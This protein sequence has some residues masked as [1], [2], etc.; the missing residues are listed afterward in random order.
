MK[1]ISVGQSC[2]RVEVQGSQG[3]AQFN[4]EW[5]KQFNVGM[6]VVITGF[7][8]SW[9]DGVFFFKANSESTKVFIVPAACRGCLNTCEFFAG[10]GG[11]SHAA[12][13]MGI[14]PVLL[15][16]AEENVA[17]ATAKKLGIPCMSA[18]EYVKMILDGHQVFKCMLHDDVLNPDT[19]VVVGLANIAYL[20]G[21]PP[22]QPW[23]SAGSAQGLKC[24]D[25]R[26]FLNTLKQAA[27]LDIRAAVIENVPGLPKHQDFRELI[28][29]IEAEGLK[30]HVQGTFTCAKI[31]PVQRDR[32]LGTFIHESVEVDPAKRVMANA[33]SFADRAFESVAKCPTIRDADVLHVNMSSAEMKQLFICE[34]LFK[35]LS[36]IEYAPTWLKN[37]L[38][39]IPNPSAEQVLQARVVI[40][41]QQFIGFMAM[42][43]KQHNIPDDLLKAK[44]LQT[45]VVRD[46]NGIRY[47]SPWEMI[48]SMGYASDTILSADIEVSWRMAGNGLS[49]AHAWLQLY[50][51]HVLLGDE[52]PFSPKGTPVQQVAAFQNDAIK[53]SQWESQIAGH[54]WE[55]KPHVEQPPEKKVRT[56]IANTAYDVESI[57]PTIPFTALDPSEGTTCD[58]MT[59]PEFA[60]I[61]DPRGIA[62]VGSV[63]GGGM[64]ALQHA[65]KNW[66]MFV[67]TEPSEVV[68]K[69]VLKAL[70]HAKI[71]HFSEMWIEGRVVSWNQAVKCNPSQRLV[72]CPVFTKISCREESLKVAL[73]LQVDVTWTARTAVAYSAVKLGCN[74]DALVVACNR[75]PL[76]DDDFLLEYETTEFQ[77]KFK[78][79]MPGYISW[80]P[81]ARE[82]CD[83]G[84]APVP[85]TMKR[86][87][88]RHPTKKTVRT[89]CVSHNTSV[90]Q[91]VQGV[92]PDLHATTAW[93]A[94]RDDVEIKG[95][96]KVN[97]IGAIQVQWNGFRPL[98]ATVIST[99]R[100]HGKSADDAALQIQYTCSGVKRHVRSP[101]KVRCDELTLAHDMTIGEIA[102]SFMTVAQLQV[103][104]ICTQGAHVLDPS[105]Y[106]K[107]TSPDEVLSFR[108]CPL[109]GGAKNDARTRIGE[110]LRSKGVPENKLEERLKGLFE[111]VSPDKFKLN[112]NDDAFWTQVKTVAS[113][114][115]YRLITHEELKA[116][117]AA[118]RKGKAKEASSAVK[119]KVEKEAFAVDASRIAIDVSHF[120]ANDD[121]VNLIEATRFGPDQTGLCVV[122][123][124]DVAKWSTAGVKSCDPL[125]LL[126]VGK[127]CH[128]YGDV[129][130]IP[131]HTTGGTPIIV[132]GCI[133][134]YGDVPIEFNLRIPSVVVDQVASTAIEFTIYRSH[135]TCWEDVTVPLHYIGVHIPELRGSNLL[136]TWSIKSWNKQQLSHVSKADHWHGFFRIADNMLCAVL[137]R[138]GGA[139]IFLNPKTP[140]RKHDPRFV[141]ISLPNGKLPDVLAKAEACP[142]AVGVVKKGE[143]YC[144]RCK[145]EDADQMRA[146]L[147]PETAYVETAS[148]SEDET[149]YVLT[150]VPQINRDELTV[151][152]AKASWKANAIKP[153]GMKR[154]LVAAKHEPPT[155]HLG[156]NG[157]IVVVEKAKKSAPAMQPVTMFARE[158]KVDT[159]RDPANN[160]VQVSTTSRI[161]EFK[162][163]MDDQITA[164]VDQRLAEAH[165]KIEELQ[166]ALTDV[167]ETAAKC[168]ANMSCDMS[169]MKQEQTFTR[170]KLLE[171]EASVATSGQAIIQQMQSMFATMQSSLEKTVQ[172][173]M[174]VEAEKRPRLDDSSRN[175]PFSTKAN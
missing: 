66:V 12:S 128:E 157:M 161:A 19:W 111:K 14:E 43:G 113:E 95:S 106:A 139:G 121:S 152:L 172:Q 154:W 168:H 87:F 129:F 119:P 175:D 147:M 51:T 153:Q 50:K 62:V 6:D 144:I 67:N 99:M 16:D 93:T 112:L 103:S 60:Q 74:P 110:M 71:E 68:S 123:A 9:R 102:A 13:K 76:K 4:E 63:Y 124:C 41:C 162:A 64:I 169:Q 75:I 133:I 52:S 39:G 105:V 167:K 59:M 23:S 145:R 69:I 46:A 57:P 10:L 108:I 98:R 142:K 164:A 81:C 86:W 136:A 34:E 3:M 127:G 174:S 120:S 138:S 107:D 32:W 109:I 8:L 141:A 70:P 132:Q 92:F 73:N 88:A 31:L 48:A 27:M 1:I 33:I 170:Q 85:C 42:Y 114:N 160:V 143:A 84:M 171:V 125:A 122:N 173:S 61:H 96:D 79:C 25:G 91:L 165:A 49:V 140:D 116:F 18:S 104:M 11:W 17:R 36:M 24:H 37:R 38:K 44:G 28:S 163:Q 118:G 166:T 94:F 55:L 159:I 58:L 126:V 53:L 97:D 148:F 5:C 77:L 26:V 54:F 135:V 20:L 29:G 155:S 150:N 130:N 83:V 101:F 149:L 90:Q 80:A 15:I 134:Q 72:F 30:L 47:I 21:S 158:F 151:A 89:I 22:C 82:T 117:Q 35:M 65:Q 131:A 45:M 40:D 137:G 56:H 115:K 156:I 7:E 100:H 2:C 146:F 78:A